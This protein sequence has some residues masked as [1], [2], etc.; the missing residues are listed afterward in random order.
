MKKIKTISMHREKS[1]SVNYKFIYKFSEPFYA[2]QLNHVE[3]LYFQDE[4][5]GTMGLAWIIVQ[6]FLFGL[7][8]AAVNISDIQANTAGKWA[9]SQENLSSGFPTKRVSNQ[10]PQLHRLASEFKFRL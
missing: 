6:H 10:S 4:I 8:G 3:Y 2:Q 5:A 7:I 1:Q 9:S